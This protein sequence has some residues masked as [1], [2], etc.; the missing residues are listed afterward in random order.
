MHINEYK[1]DN[2]REVFICGALFILFLDRVIPR[3][4]AE[5]DEEKGPKTN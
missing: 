1:P 5:R 2:M 3:V 4:H